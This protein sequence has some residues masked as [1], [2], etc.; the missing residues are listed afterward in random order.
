MNSRGVAVCLLP[1]TVMPR[2]AGGAVL[3]DESPV[4][5]GPDDLV[6]GDGHY[7]ELKKARNQSWKPQDPVRLLRV[8][9]VSCGR[10]PC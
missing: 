8:H 2:P 4:N 5:R 7:V 10:N 3:L 6:G 9:K 1:T